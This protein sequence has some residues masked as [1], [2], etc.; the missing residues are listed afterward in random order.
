[1]RGEGDGAAMR[2]YSQAYAKNPR[3]Y[4]LLRTLETYKKTLD[5]QTTVILRT[6]SALMKIFMQGEAG[7]K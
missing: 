7:A 3:F 5:D 1:M 2:T 6:D 4:N